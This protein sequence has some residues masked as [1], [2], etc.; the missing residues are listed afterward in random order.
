M[1][2]NT[3]ITMKKMLGGLLA[4]AGL[5]GLALAATPRAQAQFEY[6]NP[7]PGYCVS[8]FWDHQLYGWLSYQNNC[9]QSIALTWVGR[10]S[11]GAFSATITPGGK[12]NTGF[13]PAE[14]NNM[15]GFELYVCP[16]GYIPVDS[17]GNFVSGPNILYRCR[18]Q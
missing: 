14:V 15:G 9:G 6:A 10:T 17:S 4:V 18:R 7:I 13:S 3:A 2:K 8:G 11:G 16:A 5:F 12:A 1:K